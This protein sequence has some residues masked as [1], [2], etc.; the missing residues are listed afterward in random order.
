MADVQLGQRPLSGQQK[1]HFYDMR[2]R[3]KRRRKYR[4]RKGLLVLAFYLSFLMLSD[5][6]VKNMSSRE[7]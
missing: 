4:R 3:R 5:V 2:Q 1:T 7:R 6:Q